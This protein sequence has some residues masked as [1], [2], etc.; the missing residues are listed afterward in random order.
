MSAD[1]LMARI[2]E[3][4]NSLDSARQL[5]TEAQEIL[6]IR[7]E[8]PPEPEERGFFDKAWSA[9]GD[10]AHTGLDLAGFLPVVGTAADLVNAGLYAAEGDYVNAG[11]SAASAI[12][13]AGDA[14]AAARLGARGMDAVRNAGD[15]ATDAARNTITD[16]AGRTGDD[17]CFIAGTKVLTSQGAKSIEA[18]SIK[19]E[20]YA[21]DPISGQ[22][23]NHS[24]NQTLKRTVS[25]VF[26]IQVGDTTITCSPEHPFWVSD[27]G[28]RKA[29]KLKPGDCLLTRANQIVLIDSIERREGSFMVYNITVD[30]LHT[31]FVSD[32]GILVHNKPMRLPDPSPADELLAN[33]RNVQERHPNTAEPN[34]V[35][36]RENSDG[37]ITN[38]SVYDEDGLPI[39]RVDLVGSTHPNINGD[40][41]PT[42][43]VVEFTRNTNPTTGQVHANKQKYVREASPD[44]IPVYNYEVE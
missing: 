10:H 14:A 34:A 44:E 39:K 11:L 27:T 25:V 30:V 29:G 40:P 7:D 42:P 22:S 33:G 6:G 24:I 26:N 8:P 38:Y 36:Y 21:Y 37:F 13:I 16:G 17:A 43:H 35:L 19:D 32:L 1:D 15:E 4:R 31:Y 23:G 3:A 12:P 20:V 28:W 9:I 5:V 2:D 41:Q 18:L